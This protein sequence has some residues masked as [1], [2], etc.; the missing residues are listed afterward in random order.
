MRLSPCPG[1]GCHKKGERRRKGGRHSL[2]NVFGID[3][4]GEIS[5]CLGMHSFFAEVMTSPPPISGTIS[6]T[7]PPRQIA[8]VAVFPAGAGA[9]R[10]YHISSLP[11]HA[12]NNIAAAAPTEEGK[13]TLAHTLYICMLAL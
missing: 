5:P 8:A 3:W 1:M 10:R 11:S 7:S 12:K 13:C 2:R 4:F 9:C 6:F